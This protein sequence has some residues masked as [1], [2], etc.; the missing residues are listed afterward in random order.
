MKILLLLIIICSV[1]TIPIWWTYGVILSFQAHP[2]TGIISL[3]VEPAPFII[4]ISKSI[5]DYNIAEEFTNKF[6]K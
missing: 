4:G 5:W 1:I 6:I 2:I 3:A